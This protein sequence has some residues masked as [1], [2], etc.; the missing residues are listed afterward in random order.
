MQFLDIELTD[1]NGD[2]PEVIV[3]VMV[4]PSELVELYDRF[5]IQSKPFSDKEMQNLVVTWNEDVSL[6][7]Y[8]DLLND[9][10]VES[11]LKQKEKEAN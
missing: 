1:E 5:W 7:D 8:I 6:Q 2:A 11:R 3:P 9:Y 4:L 10:T